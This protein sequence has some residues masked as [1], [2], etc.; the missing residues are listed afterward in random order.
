LRTTVVGIFLLIVMITSRFYIQA[1]GASST[2]YI[3]ADGSID[4]PAAPI[5]SSDN[6]TYTL[7]GN[8]AEPVVIERSNII[9]DGDG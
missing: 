7:T 4:P 3:R 1:V 9:V 5:S 8:I 6:I 2:I